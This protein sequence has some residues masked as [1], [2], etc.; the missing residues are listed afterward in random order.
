VYWNGFHIQTKINAAVQEYIAMAASH[1]SAS[2]RY[3][4]DHG[5]SQLLQ[6]SLHETSEV[7]L[8]P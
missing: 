3:S 4:L 5:A 2:P 1:K 8:F 7:H 6:I